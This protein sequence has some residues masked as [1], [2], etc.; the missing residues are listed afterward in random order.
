MYVSRPIGSCQYCTN[1]D[2]HNPTVPRRGRPHHI[3]LHP[4]RQSPAIE[5]F[6]E[7]EKRAPACPVEHHASIS[8]QTGRGNGRVLP[9]IPG[10]SELHPL[11]SQQFEPV[12][13]F[14][15]ARSRNRE[16]HRRPCPWN[17]HH[18]ELSLA[19]LASIFGH[20][21]DDGVFKHNRQHS[22]YL[23]GTSYLSLLSPQL[24]L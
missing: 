5:P 1:R 9:P 24:I 16:H 17:P 15:S 7:R 19:R 18:I 11:D 13:Q 23:H 10:P 4:R 3:N 8:I 22:G 21:A 12:S 2:S 20:P 6:R 14:C